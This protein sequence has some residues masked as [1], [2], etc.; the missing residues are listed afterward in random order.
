MD[1]ITTPSIF[2][3][4]TAGSGTVLGLAFNEWLALAGFLLMLLTF[5]VNTYYKRKADKRQI[6]LDE[7][8]K[9][10]PELDI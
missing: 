9:K 7:I 8:R 6:S 5:G 1:E 2:S 4:V 3:Y 10:Y